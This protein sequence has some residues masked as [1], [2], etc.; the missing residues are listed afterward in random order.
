VL[1]VEYRVHE[2]EAGAQLNLRSGPSPKSEVLTK[3]NVGTV[4]LFALGES[5]DYEEDRWIRVKVGDQVGWVNDRYV[6]HVT[7]MSDAMSESANTSSKD[8]AS[9]HRQFRPISTAS[10][11]A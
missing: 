5:E 9:E 8:R 2:F 3:L 10:T 4:G 6:R 1:G 11:H 7:A